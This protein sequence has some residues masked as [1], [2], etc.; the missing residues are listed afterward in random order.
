MARLELT[1]AVTHEYSLALPT[2]GL[3]ANNVITF[4]LPDADSPARLGV[5]SDGR[6]LAVMVEWIRID[7]TAI[8]K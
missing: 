2:A 3:R 4:E 8:P 1:E 5:G 6:A 7:R